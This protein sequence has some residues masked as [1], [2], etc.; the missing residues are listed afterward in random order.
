MLNVFV[1]KA[2]NALVRGEG[3]HCN[4]KMLTLGWSTCEILCSEMSSCG[5]RNPHLKKPHLSSEHKCVLWSQAAKNPFYQFYIPHGVGVGSKWFLRSL[6]SQYLPWF[7]W[8]LWFLWLIFLIPLIPP[9][10]LTLQGSP[11]NNQETCK[12]SAPEST[13]SSFLG[14]FQCFVGSYENCPRSALMP[15]HV[16]KLQPG[17]LCRTTSH[18]C[19]CHREAASTSKTTEREKKKKQKNQL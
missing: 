13:T 14:A 16:Y 9:I 5:C 10:S 6:P 19:S 8:F 11:V 2:K 18:A 1:L 12:P 7:L 4:N 3:F 15:L 17:G